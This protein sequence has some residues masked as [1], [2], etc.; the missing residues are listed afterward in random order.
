MQKDAY[1]IVKRPLMTEKAE[2]DTQKH[3]AYHFEVDPDANKIQI[4]RAIEQIYSH[5]GVK[6]EKVRIISKRSKQRRF[7]ARY[8]KT[9]AWKKAIVFVDKEHKL[10]LF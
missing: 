3:N 8:G 1:Q 4:K 2:A 5:K 6:V 7:R 10:E 9:K